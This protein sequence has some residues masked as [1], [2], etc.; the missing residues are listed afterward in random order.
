MFY[1]KN[2]A[3]CCR[4]RFSCNALASNRRILFTAATTLAV[5]QNFVNYNICGISVATIIIWVSKCLERNIVLGYT[6]L[7]HDFIIKKICQ[8]YNDER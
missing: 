7:F 3:Y 2:D 4:W 1:N 6:R 8:E 5:F